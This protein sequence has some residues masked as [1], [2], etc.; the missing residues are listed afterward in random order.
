MGSKV[1]NKLI[2]GRKS[3]LNLVKCSNQFKKFI[4]RNIIIKFSG[5]IPETMTKPP[6]GVVFNKSA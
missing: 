3:A 4:Q 5:F 1:T 2:R 6:Q